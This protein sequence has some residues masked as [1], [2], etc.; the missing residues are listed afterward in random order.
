MARFA[1][2]SPEKLNRDVP[3]VHIICSVR[4]IWHT[5]CAPPRTRRLRAAVT[6]EARPTDRLTFSR[7]PGPRVVINYR[8]TATKIDSRA[9]ERNFARIRDN[10]REFCLRQKLEIDVQFH[11]RRRQST[12]LVVNINVNIFI[13]S[14]GCCRIDWELKKE[15]KQYIRKFWTALTLQTIT[16]ATLVPPVEK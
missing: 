9:L 13:K 14:D 3:C 16:Y 4:C 12:R 11:P 8:F 5:R 7:F 1:R 15:F 6:I 10:W 2:N